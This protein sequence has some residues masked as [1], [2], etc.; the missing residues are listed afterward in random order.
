MSPHREKMGIRYFSFLIFFL[1]SCAQVQPLGGGDKDE[2]APIPNFANSTPVFA[3]TEVRPSFIK[4]P[5]NE[6]I[7]LNN[8]STNI[9]VTPA[10]I[11]APKYEV[12]GKDLFVRFNKDEL[13]ENT[14][15]SFVFNKAIS[16]INENNDTTFTYVFSTGKTIDSLTYDVLL[17][18]AETQTPVANVFI[19]L[20][21]PSDSLD[22][23]KHRPKYVSQT[24]KEGYASFHYLSEQNVEVFAYFNKDGGKISNNS[25]IAFRSEPIQIDTIPQI[26]TLYLFSPKIAVEK[27]RILKKDISLGGK[28]TLVTNY[29][30]RPSAAQILQEETFLNYLYEKTHRTDS[31]IF[32]IEALENTTYSLNLPF[33]DTILSARIQTRKIPEYKIS[34]SDNLTSNELE[35]YDSLSLTFDIPIKSIDNEKISVYQSDSVE[36]D[37]KV[38]VDN[39]RRLLLF[40]NESQNRIRILPNAITFYNGTTYQDTVDIRF[41][42]KTEK[43]YANL[44]LKFENKPNHPLILRLYKGKEIAVQRYLPIQDSIAEFKLMNPGEYTIQVI[45]DINENRIFDLGDYPK[46]KQPEPVIWFRQ[47]ITLRANWDTSQPIEFKSLQSDQTG[48]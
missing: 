6:Y 14:T 12:K 44:E 31:T 19:G 21:M 11:T 9:S 22:P 41:A 33:R 29:N 1:V 2:S 7:K 30:H 34:Y 18:D 32:W 15:Y 20:Y 46:R 17:I 42:R 25:A 13:L 26:D 5:F 23:Y 8:P 38:Q 3:S 10:L 16:D 47:P 35:I 37:F 43:K 28:I 24:N 4:I 39:L 27:G 48:E 36:L 40:P 45:L